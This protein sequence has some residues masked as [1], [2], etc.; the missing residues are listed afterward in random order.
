[1]R[2]FYGSDG[3]Y[4]DQFNHD[5]AHEQSSAN[6]LSSEDSSLGQTLWLEALES[7]EVYPE[8][9]QSLSVESEIFWNSYVSGDSTFY[10]EIF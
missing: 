10:E 8:K 2:D 6:F 7:L 3:I 4:F 9:T 5:L 1:M